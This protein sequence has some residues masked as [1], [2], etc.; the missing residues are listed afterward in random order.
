MQAPGLYGPITVEPN[1]LAAR[2]AAEDGELSGLKRFLGPSNGG[3]Q[4]RLDQIEVPDTI[5]FDD[6][7]KPNDNKTNPEDTQ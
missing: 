1:P 4:A 7:T 5:S 2:L 6:S 3:L